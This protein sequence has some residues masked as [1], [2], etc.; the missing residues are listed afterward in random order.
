MKIFG[1]IAVLF[2]ASA[3]ANLTKNSVSS[4]ESSVPRK[5][6]SAKW[7]VVA[8]IIGKVGIT[9][10]VEDPTS[11]EI[12]DSNL[13]TC[14]FRVVSYQDNGSP[15]LISY[16]TSIWF[17]SHSDNIKTY[18]RKLTFEYKRYRGT[19]AMGVFGFDVLI[20]DK[21]VIFTDIDYYG[22]SSLIRPK[23]DL[24]MSCD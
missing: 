3:C 8:E 15:Q 23:A 16:P 17:V 2:L 4:V 6:S 7:S 20:K 18:D 14:Q 1:I 11:S 10:K 22:G 24:Q 5:P 13:E 12:S 9:G 19:N 21:K